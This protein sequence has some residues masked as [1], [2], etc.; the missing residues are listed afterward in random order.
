[1]KI[2]LLDTTLRDGEQ[3][4]GVSFTPSEKLTIAM[5]LL[6]ELHVPRVEIASA[7]VSDGEFESVK[8]VCNWA[9]KAGYLDSIEILGFIDKGLSIKWVK[10]VGARVINLLAKG[11]EKHC[12]SQLRKTP[13]Q[14]LADIKSEVLKAHEKGLT[15]NLYLEDWSNGIKASADYVYFLVDNLKDLPIKRFMLPDTL[16]IGRAHV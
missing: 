10:D 15:V 6:H 13:E 5:L 12:R 1:M 16:E 11:S 7:R 9:E 8:D 2:E 4:S 3:T 14:H